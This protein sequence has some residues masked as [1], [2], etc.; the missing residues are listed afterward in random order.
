MRTT[1]WRGVVNRYKYKERHARKM[2]IRK[3]TAILI[4]VMLTV[5]LLVGCTDAKKDSPVEEA[6]VNST[7]AVTTENYIVTQSMMEYFFN[8]YYRTFVT[9]YAD[10]L[11]QLNLDTG[12]SLTEQKYS[13]TH[14]W[15]DYLIAQTLKQVQQLLY[16]NEAA[17]AEGMALS[18]ENQQKIEDTLSRYDAAAVQNNT[19]TAYYLHTLFGE[20]VNETTIRKCLR[21]QMLAAQ[22]TEKLEEEQT[23][24]IED[25]EAHFAENSTNYSMVGL[26][27]AIVPTEQAQIFA[28]AEDEDAFVELLH[29]QLLE[30]APDLSEQDLKDKIEDAYKRR[31]QYVEDTAI[32]QWAFDISR[33]AYDTYTEEEEDGKTAVYMLLP[34]VGEP[35]GQVVYR[36]NTPVKNLE[37]ILFASEEEESADAAKAKAWTVLEQWKEEN[38]SDS[39]E[40]FETLMQE[41]GGDTSL[42]L[43][44]GRLETD[45]ENWIFDEGRQAGDTTA[46]S[47]SEGTY[48]LHMLADGDPQWQTRVRSDMQQEA[49][50]EKLEDLAETYEAK[51]SQAA[52]Y[53]ISQIRV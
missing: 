35:M 19:S 8:S 10:Q 21:L 1:L 11:D 45:L 46:I 22:Y 41:Y 38:Q 52:L 43:E 27:Y 17:L 39:R 3:I 50:E 20:S 29:A 25:L 23:Y 2:K 49:L 48:I 36:D 53:D 6:E 42:D 51:Y 44:R 37:F 31:V 4:G 12:K 15:F 47:V 14:S 40:T 18:Q 13:D 24:T 16:L 5:S 30:E 26:V 28:D 34:A 7:V 33:T 32:F 9:N